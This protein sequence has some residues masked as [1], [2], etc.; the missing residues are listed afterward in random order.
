[1]TDPLTIGMLVSAVLLLV[2]LLASKASYRLG[3]PALLVFLV[4]GMLAGSDGPGGIYFD[5]AA[6]SQSLG[7]VA[8]A[9]I[10][11]S[12]GLET[13]QR[14]VRPILWQGLSLST[15]GV[16]ITSALTGIFAHYLLGTSWVESLLLGAIVGSTDAAAVFA[17]LRSKNIS[18]KARTQPLLEFESGSNDPMA[19]LLTT[20]LIQLIQEPSRPLV[21]LVP[22]LILQLMIG[23]A[24]GLAAGR[25]ALW[26]LN[27][28]KLQSD[29][30][31][32]VLTIAIC[33][34]IY[35]GT[36]VAYGNGF[37]A[38][39]VAGIVIGN[40]EFVHKRSLL[41]FHNGVGWLMQIVMFLV[42]G[43][44]VF[45]K[46]LL[47]IAPQG[48]LLAAFLTFVAR[49][50]AV[51]AGM[52]FAKASIRQRLLISWVGLRGSVPIILATFPM[53][54]KLP[55][56]ELYFNLVFFIVLTSVLVQGTSIPTVT[57]W[58]G[59]E[60]PT[61]RRKQYPIDF[62]PAARTTND[63]YDLDLPLSSPIAGKRILDLALPRSALVVL[64]SREN[65]FVAPRGDT[66]IQGGDSL[67]VLA[68]KVDHATLRTAL[69]LPEQDEDEDTGDE[70]E[71]A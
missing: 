67:L 68:E 12:G 23:G 44:L 58:L 30:L 5:D 7:V 46:Q 69:A 28:M 53:M 52:A 43:L 50:V 47:P 62:V 11:F 55:V 48:L 63:L 34:G 17:V 15:F 21:S 2:A 6:L 8:L 70:A 57:R 9:F 1:M 54:A 32:P 49:P 41:R 16:C 13:D 59:M 71:T 33:L 36:T 19:V 29:G 4:I 3:V 24:L 56:A 37:L 42:L 35:A 64:I 26:V 66:V 40:G 51:F 31:Y 10:L 25:G 60:A 18:M 20:G 45:P 61:P 27:R 14:A 38:V 22:T 65:D 39:Y